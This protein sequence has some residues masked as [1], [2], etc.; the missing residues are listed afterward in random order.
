MLWSIYWYN[1]NLDNCHVL[2]MYSTTQGE[3]TAVAKNAKD[4]ASLR[5]TVPMSMVRQWQLKPKDKLL[6]RWRVIEGKMVA[7]VDKH[8]DETNQPKNIIKTKQK[9]V[10]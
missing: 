8:D 6:W 9:R 4:S 5:T 3:V 7:I 1:L 10:L 2:A